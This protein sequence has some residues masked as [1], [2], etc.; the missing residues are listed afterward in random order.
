R[1]LR[2]AF[3]GA[4]PTGVS[5][6]IQVAGDTSK[7][8]SASPPPPAA[9][10]DAIVLPEKFGRYKVE[11]ILGRGGMGAVFL[12]EDVELHRRVA[13]KVP[14]LSMF[15]DPDAGQR[16]QREARAAA[17][18]HHPHICPVFDV[19]EFNG[20]R[21]LTM[22]YIDGAPLSKLVSPSKPVAPKKAAAAI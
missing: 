6:F 22:A 19:G 21:Y 1:R 14:T 18:L 15:H 13:L 11:R 17:V 3:P 8:E 7:V 4:K 12:A 16:F 20:I 9:G 2:S 5:T 10:P